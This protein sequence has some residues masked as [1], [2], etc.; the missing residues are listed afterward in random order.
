MRGDDAHFARNLELFERLCARRAIVSA[1]E[2]L[3]MM[4][5]TMGLLRCL[6]RVLRFAPLARLSCRESSE[7]ALTCRAFLLGINYW[8]RRSAMYMWQ[9]F[10]ADEIR[11][12]VARIKDMGLDVVRFFLMWEAFQPEPQ[13]HGLHRAAP[14]RSSDRTRRRCG[15]AGDAD[16]VLRTH[17]RLQLAAVLDART[18]LARRDGFA[19]SST[20]PWSDASIGDFY[21]DPVLL[22]AQVYCAQRIGER[23]QDH[24]AMLAWDLGNEF[25]NLRIPATPSDAAE[26]S[27]RLSET[28]RERI[29]RR[30]NR[31]HAR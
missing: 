7:E 9:R 11:E 3:P 24:P 14:F 13:S 12:D 4:M 8:P 30:R 29:G 22:D 18:R 19:R 23:V 16:A 31:R 17:E 15:I 20:T 21:A 27:L 1:S 5:P 28:L 2:R 6:H 26:W 10:D 25:S